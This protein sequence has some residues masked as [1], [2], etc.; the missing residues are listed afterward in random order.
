M[1]TFVCIVGLP[2]RLILVYDIIYVYVCLYK[3][4]NDIDVLSSNYI[5]TWGSIN[6]MV[7]VMVYLVS[8]TYNV[9]MSRLTVVPPVRD[10]GDRHPARVQVAVSH[11]VRR[12]EPTVRLKHITG[13]S[14]ALNNINT[15]PRTT[16]THHRLIKCS[17]Q[18]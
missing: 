5:P 13:S 11:G 17:Q 2:N 6:I 14:N 1:Q 10:G 9:C 18:H 8:T 16:E 15:N 3:C 4:T 7:M 12:H